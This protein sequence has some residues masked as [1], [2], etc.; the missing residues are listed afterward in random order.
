MEHTTSYWK[1][2]NLHRHVQGGHQ[3]AILLH[4]PAGKMR[5]A[6]LVEWCEHWKTWTSGIGEY[7]SC[8]RPKKKTLSLASAYRILGTYNKIICLT[9]QRLYL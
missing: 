7:V 1:K 8:C 6:K 2:H 3:L 9:R 4:T 5:L